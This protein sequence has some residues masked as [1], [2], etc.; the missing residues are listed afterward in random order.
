MSDVN[1]ALAHRWF[2]EVW[3]EGREATID[4]LLAPDG[5][6][7]GLGESEKDTRGPHEFKVFFQNLRGLLPDIH[8]RIEDIVAEGD[9]VVVR[10]LV[11][12]THEGSGLGTR[13]TGHRV[14]FAGIVILQFYDGRIVRAWN[15]WDQLGFLR[16]IGAA[17]V[18]PAP[19]AD[20]F[21]ERG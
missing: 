16:Q 14:K 13:P 15:S 11:E 19:T 10:L 12:G 3:N 20:R 7:V 1:K 8:M 5:L 17:A 2:Q 4:E 6:A 18:R 9:K 21:L